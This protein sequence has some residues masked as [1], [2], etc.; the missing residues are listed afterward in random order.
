[1]PD[2]D[3]AVKTRL[4]STYLSRCTPDTFRAGGLSLTVSFTAVP[5]TCE[6]DQ[7]SSVSK[8]NVATHSSCFHEY[9]PG[10]ILPK[11]KR[12]PMVDAIGSETLVQMAVH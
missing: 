4:L 3:F 5:R 10:V 6:V 11:R 8:Q 12:E 2:M 7:L 1:M 9:F